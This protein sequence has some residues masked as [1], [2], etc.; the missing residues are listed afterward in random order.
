[1]PVTRAAAAA[2]AAASVYAAVAAGESDEEVRRVIAEC[3]DEQ[4]RTAA[5]NHK[6]QNSNETPLAAAHRLRRGD[7]VGALL[8]AGAD[9]SKLFRRAT[10][11][12]L[13]IAYGLADSLRVLLKAGHDP[14]QQIGYGPHDS[15]EGNPYGSFC[16]AAHLCLAPPRLSPAQETNPTDQVLVAR[17]LAHS[18]GRT[19]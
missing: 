16:T 6:G 12:V 1:M 15:L 19:L 2:G 11:L 8:E 18:D 4:Q 3:G 9:A 13:C 14:N 10:P 5:V 7:L 17:I